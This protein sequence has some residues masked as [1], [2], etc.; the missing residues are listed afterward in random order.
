MPHTKWLRLSAKTA[1]PASVAGIASG[2]PLF[3][4]SCDWHYGFHAQVSASA[5]HRTQTHHTVAVNVCI[6]F[7]I[8]FFFSVPFHTVNVLC[9]F[10][11]TFYARYWNVHPND[12]LLKNVHHST[13]VNREMKR[14]KN[15]YLK[16]ANYWQQ[17]NFWFG[18]RKNAALFTTSDSSK[19][20]L[21]R[22][23]YGLCA[24]CVALTNE[25]EKPRALEKKFSPFFVITNCQ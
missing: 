20:I 23:V 2:E 15:V 24:Y 14:K 11:N 10:V 16:Y 21:F 7:T 8:P 1:A 18:C 12:M 19:S 13:K 3:E 9:V 25:K 4:I 17:A 22:Y 5:R 6:F